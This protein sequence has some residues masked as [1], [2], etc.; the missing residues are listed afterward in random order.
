[1]ISTCKEEMKKYEL[2]EDDVV[3][4]VRQ[5]CSYVSKIKITINT[6]QNSFRGKETV[7]LEF[8]NF[9]PL[10]YSQLAKAGFELEY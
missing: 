9:F 1:M 5:F 3:F 8:S 2:T 4:L 10:K 6:V 7:S